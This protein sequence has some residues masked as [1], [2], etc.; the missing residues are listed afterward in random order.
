[1]KSILKILILSVSAFISGGVFAQTK[2]PNDCK[3]CGRITQIEKVRDAKSGVGGA[4]IGG[5]AG[6]LLGNQIGGGKGKTA[7]TVV[8]AA[9]GAYA[10]K[11]IAERNMEY[12]ITVRMQD[13]RIETVRQEL[14][15]NMRVGDVV[16]IK[17]GK[18]KP[19]K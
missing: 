18:A 11:E 3:A 16:K 6:G 4:I 7:A 2:L 9:S 5:I 8:G 10:G 17:D 14:L 19:Y 13:G 15:H 1:M 12:Q